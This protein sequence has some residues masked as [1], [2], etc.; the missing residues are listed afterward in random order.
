[1]KWSRD[2]TALVLRFARRLAEVDDVLLDEALLGGT[3]LYPNFG[4][5]TA[6]DAERPL[7]QEFR[8]GY[9]A[10]EDPVEWTHRFYLAHARQYPPHP[11]GCFRYHY[12]PETRTAGLHFGNLDS[13]GLGSL[14]RER[15]PVRLGEL[16]A[17]FADIRRAHPDAELFQGGSWLYNLPAYQ[18]LF[19]PEYIA[20]LAQGRPS[21]TYFSTWGQLLDGCWRVRAEPASIFIENIEAATN[22][23]NLENSFPLPSLRA[24]APIRYFYAFYGLDEDTP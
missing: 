21:F 2:F 16:T 20:S 5:G 22:H 10:A 13:S 8:E 6:F 24:R 12:N 3:P 19:P 15:R 17:M 1:M 7:W 4:L 23:E 11:Y 18:A 14:S 9:R